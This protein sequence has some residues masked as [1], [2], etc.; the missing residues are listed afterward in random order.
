MP[1]ISSFFGILIYMYS[2]DHNPPHF[3]AIYGEYKCIISIKNYSL[4]EG[5]LPPK[6]LSLVVEWASLHQSELMENWNRML[7][8]E[9]FKSINP[10]F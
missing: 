4:L 7:N 9:Q 3:H 2:R 10:L 8:F 1:R 6:A 5:Y